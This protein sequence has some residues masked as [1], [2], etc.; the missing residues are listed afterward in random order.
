MATAA[1]IDP[2]S[3]NA[4]T[5]R[6]IIRKARCIV[7]ECEELIRETKAGGWKLSL[8]AFE[9]ARYAALEILDLHGAKP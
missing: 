3:K 9:G 4:R 2:R 1:E 6:L 8:Q 5:R 7:R